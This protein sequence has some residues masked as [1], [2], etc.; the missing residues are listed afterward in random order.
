MNQYNTN[1]ENQTCTCQDWQET[2]QEFRQNDPRNS[3][4]NKII[5][6]KA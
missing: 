2:R 5:Y 6:I 3:K 4:T 1:L